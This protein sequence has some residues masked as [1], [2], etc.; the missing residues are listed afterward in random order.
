MLPAASQNLMLAILSTEVAAL[1]ILERSRGTAGWGAAIPT[2]IDG[3]VG[4]MA[5][6]AESGNWGKVSPIAAA[7][8]SGDANPAAAASQQTVS[9]GG[10]G[11]T[12]ASVTNPAC[13]VRC[14]ELVGRLS[15]RD[16]CVFAFDWVAYLAAVDAGEPVDPLAVTRN[17]MAVSLAREEASRASEGAEGTAMSSGRWR[18]Q[19]EKKSKRGQG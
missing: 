9:E 13:A 1:A 16:Q 5:A 11:G 18:L 8:A 3:T 17:P 14:P 15:Q 19:R 4:A 7:F 12:A 10:I 6:Y 2:A